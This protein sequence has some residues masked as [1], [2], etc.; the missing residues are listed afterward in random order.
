ML[1][2]TRALHHAPIHQL[3]I[4][5]PACTYSIRLDKTP[6]MESLPGNYSFVGGEGNLADHSVTPRAEMGG[7]ADGTALDQCHPKVEPARSKYDGISSAER[8]TSSY[9]GTSCGT[10]RLGKVI[11]ESAMSIEEGGREAF[12]F[13]CR[14]SP[15]T[16]HQPSKNL[17]T[18]TRLSGAGGR[19]PVTASASITARILGN[20]HERFTMTNPWL[21]YAEDICQIRSTGG[22]PNDRTY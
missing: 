6:R 10:P 21:P 9:R 4:G 2:D 5:G 15:V 20:P 18:C 16:S 1:S 22:I 8:S 11:G 13:P 14:F 19:Q 7:R 17:P 3:P 12:P